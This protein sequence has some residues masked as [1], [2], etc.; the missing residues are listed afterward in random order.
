MRDWN[1]VAT[2][3]ERHFA[4][5][6][7][8]L[9]EFGPAEKTHYYDVLV[10]RVPDP[11]GFLEQLH[12]DQPQPSRP[13]DVLSRVAPCSVTFNFQSPQEFESRAAVAVREFLPALAGARFH[14]RMHRRGF[15]NRLRSPSEEQLLDHT[16]LSALEAMGAP[17]A[18]TF[19]DPDAIVDLETVDTRAGLGV[20]TRDDLQ[21]FPLLHLD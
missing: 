19:D 1:V 6:L 20:W 9:R 8:L 21:R 4:E 3:R 10:A 5:A 18:I 14:V 15:K 12:Q 16:L 2:V 13:A 11:R 17:G 7:H